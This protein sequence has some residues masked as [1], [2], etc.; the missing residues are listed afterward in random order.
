MTQQATAGHASLSPGGAPAMLRSAAH[1]TVALGSLALVAGLVIWG[2]DTMTRETR[3]VPVV[4]AFAGAMRIDPAETG[5]DTVPYRDLTVGRV[6]EGKGIA[7]APSVVRVAAT[8]PDLS[9]DDFV[10]PAAA[11]VPARKEPVPVDPVEAQRTATD[12]AVMSVMVAAQAIPA[13]VP[14][15]ARSL[16][17]RGRPTTMATTQVAASAPELGAA[18]HE[19][20]PA[21]LAAGTP[22]AQLGAFPDQA[23]ARA[24]W[25]ALASRHESLLS[26]RDRVL[27]E[28]PVAGRVLWRLRVAGFDAREDAVRFCTAL[29]AAG[30]ECIPTTHG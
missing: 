8:G 16:R 21:A 6:A 11:D 2:H 26:G 1:W 7:P 17:P 13:D 5:G 19:L 15:V 14:G 28:V 27:I 29:S 20:D 23:S 10:Q 25:G 3:G 12:R 30:S 24:A 18:G 4:R 22:L 9:T